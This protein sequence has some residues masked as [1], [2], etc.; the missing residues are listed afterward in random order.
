M[1]LGANVRVADHSPATSQNAASGESAMTG[2]FHVRQ[3][4]F[5]RA[6]WVS[7]HEIKRR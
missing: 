3:F 1:P 6:T 7:Y 4:V 5:R 2:E